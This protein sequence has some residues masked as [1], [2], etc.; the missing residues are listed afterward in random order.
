MYTILAKLKNLKMSCFGEG[1]QHWEFSFTAAHPH[2]NLVF[3]G[4]AGE[5]VNWSLLKQS[6]ALH[7]KFE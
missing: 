6:L 3:S 2:Q 7:V 1:A 4:F 5:N